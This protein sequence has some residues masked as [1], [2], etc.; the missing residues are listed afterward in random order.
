MKSITNEI[1][2]F[3]MFLYTYVR[4]V[5]SLNELV[6]YPSLV[7]TVQVPSEL[8]IRPSLDAYINHNFFHNK[9]KL[10]YVFNGSIHIMI[11]IELSNTEKK[12]AMAMILFNQ[13]L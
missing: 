7:L 13:L 10:G 2:F 3:Y 9:G 6:S 4:I 11:M 12:L 5:F 8:N 1:Y